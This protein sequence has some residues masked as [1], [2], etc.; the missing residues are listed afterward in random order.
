MSFLSK[1]SL[2][3][4]VS[5]FRINFII[6][7]LGWVV[8]ALYS[9]PERLHSYDYAGFVLTDWLI[10]YEGGF[11]RRGLMGQ[12]LYWFYQ[13][14]PYPVHYVVMALSVLSLLSFVCWVVYLYRRERWSMMS[15]VCTPFLG[16]PLFA[17][18]GWRRDFVIL[19]LVCFAFYAVKRYWEHRSLQWFILANLISVFT[20]LSHEASFFFMIPLLMVVS[21]YHCRATCSVYSSVVR[22][23]SLFI[24]PIL[25]MGAC[26]IFKG[27]TDV[28]QAI[29]SSWQPCIER[30]PLNCADIGS[31][32][33]ALTWETWRTFKFHLGL[34]FG[35]SLSEA[36]STIPSWPLLLLSYVAVYYLTS[37]LNTVN[38]QFNRM[39]DYDNILM[40]CILLLQFVFLLPMFTVLSCDVC[41]ISGYW[42]FSSLFAFHFFK[43][44]KL[45]PECLIRL[46]FLWQQRID[47][48]CWLSS[49]WT[50]ILI[51]WF[52]PMHFVG[53]PSIDTSPGG[54]IVAGIVTL[55][56]SFVS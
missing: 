40:S 26:V 4:K 31:G 49:P 37:R 22:V 15:L 43:E 2:L 18:N 35:G 32:V 21:W 36:Y 9:L 48:S 23:L 1:E 47:K 33:K 51:I 13:W 19:L 28:A 12:I 17:F 24:I 25:S 5:L 8:A 41:R 30:Y 10:N 11:V 3:S 50:Y 45:Y 46:S 20:I 44:R 34:N 42:I 53:A 39:A 16:Y 29:W 54:K 6:L 14:H 27:G 56:M 38:L 52:I 55:V 7:A